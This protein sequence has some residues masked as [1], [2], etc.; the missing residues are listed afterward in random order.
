MDLKTPKLRA[1][2]VGDGTFLSG[3]NNSFIRL[4]VYGD[5]PNKTLGIQELCDTWS[6]N[7]PCCQKVCAT[8]GG[9]WIKPHSK[10]VQGVGG[11]DEVGDKSGGGNGGGA[12]GSGSKDNGGGSGGK[13]GGRD[14]GGSSD[15]GSDDF[16]DVDWSQVQGM[17]DASNKTAGAK[18]GVKSSRPTPE[19]PGQRPV[20]S[21]VSTARPSAAPAT[22]RPVLASAS[23]QNAQP[24]KSLQ[25]PR[26]RPPAPPPP[27][28]D[29]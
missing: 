25:R 26:P 29:R 16:G 1:D 11:G 3:K 9:I 24:D 18:Q 23:K 8:P 19:T 6:T 12:S 21:S 13:G 27:N 22:V 15:Y 20:N 4:L 2:Y 10:G 7:I 28:W 5:R 14:K 17:N